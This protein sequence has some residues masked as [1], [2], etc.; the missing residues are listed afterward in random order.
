MRVVVNG[1]ERDIPTGLTVAQLL[2]H[3]EVDPTIVA[4]ERNKEIVPRS[5][6]NQV[7]IKEGDI[8]EIVSFVGGGA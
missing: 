2:E 7:V 3:L 4:V 5:Q 1:K 6:F 8:L